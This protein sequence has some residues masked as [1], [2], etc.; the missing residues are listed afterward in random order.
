MNNTIKC[1]NCETENPSY[2]FVCLKCKSYIRERV[3]NIDF[4]LTFWKTFESPVKTFSNVIFAEHK[5]FLSFILFLVSVKLS[6]NTFVLSNL[7]NPKTNLTSNIIENL[8]FL[9]ISFFAVFVISAVLL[10]I[11]L[12]VSNINSRFKDNLA[13]L[14]YAQTP[15]LF[16]LFFI[17][18]VQLGVFGIHWFIFNPNPIM[19]KSTVAYTFMGIDL[20]L[21]IW[22]FIQT[23]IAHF[24]QTR[25][26]F[27]SI[28]AAIIFYIIINGLFLIFPFIQ[29]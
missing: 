8:F 17:F 21:I 23:I 2:R 26:V 1:A 28:I 3:F 16:S 15:L 6:V 11:I 7:I 22:G 27:Y 29:S 20:I 13:I 9:I 5:N 12:K 19:I 18:P 4:W 25:S 24:V 10:K 14:T